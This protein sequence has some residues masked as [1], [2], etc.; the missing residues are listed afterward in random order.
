MGNDSIFIPSIFHRVF[1]NAEIADGVSVDGIDVLVAVID[2]T[3]NP[4]RGEPRKGKIGGF[5][6]EAAFEG[7]YV[8]M[9]VEDCGARSLVRSSS[10]TGSGNNDN[11]ATLYTFIPG[12]NSSH[13]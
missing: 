5:S 7:I 1:E 6:K 13:E 12:P 10:N 3:P 2:K 9:S 11:S 4:N 8:H